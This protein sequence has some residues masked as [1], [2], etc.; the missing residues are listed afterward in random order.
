MKPKTKV[1]ILVGWLMFILL[2]V[3]MGRHLWG[4]TAHEWT[5]A[6]TFVL[7]IL[8]QV[9]NLDWYRRVFKG[10]YSPLRILGLIVNALVLTAMTGMIISGI[11][12]SQ[13]VFA[14]LPIKGGTA[15]ARL[16]H[17]VATYWGFVIIGLHLGLHWQIIVELHWK[18][19]LGAVL[20]NISGMVPDI[21]RT[22]GKTPRPAA[23]RSFLLNITGM[24][25]AVY[26]LY[27]FLDRGLLT[28]MFLQNQFVFLDSG[29]SRIFFYLD[30]LA[31]TGLFV[32]AAHNAAKFL[33]TGGAFRKK[34]KPEVSET[35]TGNMINPQEEK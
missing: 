10:R 20:G 19:V 16:L 2:M 12:L 13:Q 23:V 31:M 32:W 27:A 15:F 9:L 5:G 4:N 21:R 1:K 8:H 29:E 17:M 35:L 7:F 34:L 30:H 28:Y 24:V 3:Q 22:P 14:F 33:R 6:G 25:I 18:K 26:G 11:I